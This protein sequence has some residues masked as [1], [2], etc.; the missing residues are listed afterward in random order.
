MLQSPPF[1]D[2][3]AD[4][5]ARLAGLGLDVRHVEGGEAHIAV[6]DG[7][8]AETEVLAK[9]VAA[10]LAVRSFTPV[11]RTLE[12]AYLEEAGRPKASGEASAAKKAAAK[13][14]VE[15]GVA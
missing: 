12:Q 5:A 1:A 3:P 9:L 15:G 7:D 6:G 2:P 4:L 8:K 10:G 11:R 14:P 13:N